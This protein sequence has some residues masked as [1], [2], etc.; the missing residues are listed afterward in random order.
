MQ[1]FTVL[2]DTR[3][4]KGLVFPEFMHVLLPTARSIKASSATVVQIKR[5]SATLDYG[6]YTIEGAEDRV[7]IERKRSHMEI[8]QNCL[9][10]H[11]YKALKDE[12]IAFQRLT[13]HP[14][15]LAE[16]RRSMISAIKPE[17][18]SEAVAMDALCGL[19]VDY[20]VHLL[21]LPMESIKQRRAA[22]EWILRLMLACALREPVP[23][24]IPWI[25][26]KPRTRKALATKARAFQENS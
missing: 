21:I 19:L 26:M 13:Q 24:E 20:G 6:D 1:T 10:T 9:L 23:R 3:E 5:R 15:L 4:Q 2:I 22:G 16:G 8:R 7:L 11:R 25:P 14:Y 17:E 18:T 12:M